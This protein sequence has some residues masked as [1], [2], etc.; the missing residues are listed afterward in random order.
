MSALNMKHLKYGEV[1]PEFFE[2]YERDKKTLTP[3]E[4]K[5]IDY[6]FYTDQERWK[7]QTFEDGDDL[8]Q[9]IVSSIFFLSFHHRGQKS[10]D[11]EYLIAKCSPTFLRHIKMI[12]ICPIGGIWGN[13]HWDKLPSN[14][15]KLT[16]VTHMQINTNISDIEPIR[17]MNL[18]FLCLCGTQVRNIEPVKGMPLWALRLM[19][20]PIESIKPIEGSDTL[21]WVPAKQTPLDKRAIESLESVEYIKSIDLV[22][23]KISNFPSQINY[24]QHVKFG[25]Y[26]NNQ[27]PTPPKHTQQHTFWFGAFLKPIKKV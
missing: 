9:T 27:A 3:E 17:G 13:V 18:H 26:E 10:G 22:G 25:K 23:T 16:H 21:T 15:S 1:L 2:I 14:I 7:K 5:L 24:A 11:M 20:T 12:D 19:N 8:L 4:V 6:W